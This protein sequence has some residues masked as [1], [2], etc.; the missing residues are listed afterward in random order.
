MFSK[1]EVAAWHKV[2]AEVNETLL[3]DIVA[4]VPG[5]TRAVLTGGGA[6]N[7]YLSQ[8]L[9]NWLSRHGIKICKSAVQFPC[10]RGALL[11]YLFET[12]EPIRNATFFVIQCQEYDPD[13]HSDLSLPSQSSSVVSHTAAPYKWDRTETV[14]HD[15]LVPIMQ[16]ADHEELTTHPVP[17]VF[18]IDNATPVACIS[19]CIA[20][21]SRTVTCRMAR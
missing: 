21:F 4:M 1:S 20:P 7:R 10:S 12:D 18:H 19:M 16:I 2:W 15:R 5:C 13:L 9:K 11:H 6:H 8:R 14:V 3:D 17:M